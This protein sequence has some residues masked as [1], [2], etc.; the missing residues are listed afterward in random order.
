MKY[1]LGVV[2]VIFIWPLFKKF[3]VTHRWIKCIRRLKSMLWHDNIMFDELS[4]TI[5]LLTNQSRRMVED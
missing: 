4:D 2:V 3:I 5:A 1:V